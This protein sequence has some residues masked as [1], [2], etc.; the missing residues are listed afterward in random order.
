MLSP[1]SLLLRLQ[2]VPPGGGA[3]GGGR[4]IMDGF[5]GPTPLPYIL[6]III[7]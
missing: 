4:T 5:T 3:H 7:Y 1:S 2:K 6:L